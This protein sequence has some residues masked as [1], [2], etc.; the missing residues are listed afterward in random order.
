MR[1]CEAGNPGSGTGG[2]AR[3]SNARWWR[4]LGQLEQEALPS[5]S[6]AFP[7]DQGWL[8]GGL[9]LEE[10][11]GKRCLHA[12]GKGVGWGG[13]GCRLQR[14][15]SSDAAKSLCKDGGL[16]VSRFVPALIGTKPFLLLFQEISLGVHRSVGRAARGY[17]SSSCTK[18][19]SGFSLLTAYPPPPC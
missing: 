16:G 17:L 13:V 10:W 12:G 2:G 18:S 6:E 19:P 4:L 7:G 3:L 9:L 11:G 15:P 1:V 5:R 14:D 8:A